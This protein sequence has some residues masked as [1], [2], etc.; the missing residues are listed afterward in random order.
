MSIAFS[1]N[2]I[3]NFIFFN[4]TFIIKINSFQS[5]QVKKKG[6]QKSLKTG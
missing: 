4:E 2:Y 1:L 5:E 3:N 6:Y